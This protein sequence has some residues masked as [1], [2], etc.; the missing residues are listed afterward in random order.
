M[1]TGQCLSRQAR[2][3]VTVGLEP[4]SPKQGYRRGKCTCVKEKDSL[5][6]R[7]RVKK[8]KKEGADTNELGIQQMFAHKG[9]IEQPPPPR[10]DT[11]E[12]SAG[13]KRQGHSLSPW[14]NWEEDIETVLEGRSGEAAD[15][16]GAPVTPSLPP[17]AQITAQ[18]PST[19]RFSLS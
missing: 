4:P 9:R 3:Q 11:Q 17:E 16:P 14:E 10:V 1:Q 6:R 2:I 8:E 19:A 7:T 12:P 18:T 13:L 15:K 5:N